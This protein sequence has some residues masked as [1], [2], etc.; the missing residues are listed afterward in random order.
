MAAPHHSLALTVEHHDDRYWWLLIALDSQQERFATLVESAVAF[1]SYAD[2]LRAG[3]AALI[4]ETF[5]G[6]LEA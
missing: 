2:A 1:A 4:L 6:D 3:C 5:A